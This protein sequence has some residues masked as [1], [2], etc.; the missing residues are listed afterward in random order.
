MIDIYT[1]EDLVVM[2]VVMQHGAWS[3]SGNMAWEKGQILIMK[4]IQRRKLFS[5]LKALYGAW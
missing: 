5:F 1:L 2:A 4:S 3:P